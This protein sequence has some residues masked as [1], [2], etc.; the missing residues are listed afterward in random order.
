M[1]LASFGQHVLAARTKAGMSQYDLARATGHAQQDLSQMEQGN[2]N[3]TLFTACRIAEALGIS[4]YRLLRAP[5]HY[6][7]AGDDEE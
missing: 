2:R 1:V 5:R 3:V 6:Q 7:T 4:P